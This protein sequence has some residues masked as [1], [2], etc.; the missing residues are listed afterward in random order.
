MPGAVL[1]VTV[2]AFTMIGE[3]FRKRFDVREGVL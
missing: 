1:F 2:L 3:H